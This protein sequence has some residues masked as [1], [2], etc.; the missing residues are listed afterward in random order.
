M[1]RAIKKAASWPS[2]QRIGLSSAVP[3]QYGCSTGRVFNKEIR[4]R[5]KNPTARQLSVLFSW[6]QLMRQTA[7][8]AVASAQVVSYRTQRMARAVSDP[9]TSGA[10]EFP[11]MWMEKVDAAGRASRALTGGDVARAV[12]ESSDLYQRLVRNAWDTMSLMRSRTPSQFISRY[13]RWMS[14]WGQSANS[15]A[16]AATA[17]TKRTRKVIAPYHSASTRNAVRLR[18]SSKTR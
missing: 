11:L 7:E 14:S 9:H 4:M 15:M 3:R 1:Q 13:M 17:V 6:Y 5:R 12:Q 18:R 10:S 16:S 8:M 2:H